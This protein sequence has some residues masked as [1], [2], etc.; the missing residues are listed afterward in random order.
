MTPYPQKSPV[1]F[2]SRLSVES[3][4]SGRIVGDPETILAITTCA[5]HQ[6]DSLRVRRHP[7]TIAKGAKRGAVTTQLWAG[8]LA[9]DT[10]GQRV[11][12]F[13][14]E[15]KLKSEI[16]VE[17]ESAGKMRAAQS[18]ASLINAKRGPEISEERVESN[19]S[20]ESC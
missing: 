17:S 1:R 19:F 2:V 16:P 11:Y 4:S 13:C 7:G 3:S 6:S 15:M 5:P 12:I 18:S 9:L 14:T 10:T 8:R 20:V